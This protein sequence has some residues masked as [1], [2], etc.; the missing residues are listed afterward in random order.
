M[1]YQCIVV[2]TVINI[3]PP[4][5][6]TPSSG[7][8]NG[9]I[10]WFKNKIKRAVAVYLHSLKL[11]PNN[12]II[13]GNLACIYYKQ[14]FIDLAIETYRR[15][16]EFQPNFPDAYCNLANALKEKGLV[17]EAE[18][19]YNKALHL[20]P[21]HVDTLNNLGNVK[22]EQGKIEEATKLYMRALEVFPNFAA[23][24]SNLA[25]LLQHQG[26]L[27]EAL[28]HYRQAISVQPKFADAYSNMG[29]TLRELQD[30][31]G[32]FVCFKKAIEINPCFADAHCNLASIYKDMG[33]ITD[34]IESYK[35]AL[36]LK[37]E[38]PDAY[39]NL[40]HCLQII[41]NWDHYNERMSNIISIV[42][43]QLSFEKLTSVH[44]HHS[45]LYPL[46][47]KVR[48]EI[49]SRHA[50]IFSEKVKMFEHLF[51]NHTRESKGRLRVGYVSSD[52]G[53]HPTSHLMQSIP[54]LH[55]QE[56]IEV[57]CYALN[58]N[59]GTTF[60]SKI[61][62]ESEHYID[63]SKI[64]CN[65]EAAEIIKQNGI[66]I[67]I[68]MNGYTKGARNEIFALKPAPIQVMWLGYPGTSGAD[69]M[70]YIITDETSSPKWAENDFS[71]KFAYMS[72]TYF[73]G[74]HKQ[75]FPHLKTQYK[76]NIELENCLD[77]N[78]AFINC[79][80]NVNIDNM[81][82]TNHKKI[83]LS[84]KQYKPIEVIVRTIDIPSYVVEMT[85]NP[86]QIMVLVEGKDIDNGLSINYTNKKVASGENIR[87]GIVITSRKQYGLPNDAIIY[88]NF[89]Q[90]YKIDPSVMET[91]VNILKNVP[92][93][94]LWLL[95]FPAAGEPNIRKF[96]QSL[97]LTPDRII[98]SKI[99]CKEEHVR[100]GQL[101]DVCLDTPLCNGHTTAMDV[102]WTGTPV[103]TLP[104]ET[105]ASRVAASQLNA[106]GCSELIAKSKQEYQD[107]AV[108]LGTNSQYRRY[109]R[110]KVSKA[111]LES[112]LFDC[113]HYARGLETLY[114]NMWKCY[115]SGKELHHI[116]VSVD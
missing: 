102:L 44:P 116:R 46:S 68:N 40:V 86:K 107:L 15:A 94:V 50:N 2:Y 69:F 74:D 27:H 3:A 80:E 48:K 115:Q 76:V 57:F 61:N 67:L 21:A 16:I 82:C 103:I 101:A 5:L 110:A 59:D 42:E 63:L 96:A 64:T 104:G 79:A 90:L 56:K 17:S 109:I 12:G 37:P 77:I 45:I 24:H 49:A 112:T 51:F 55:N 31:T 108:R 83:S 36:K 25:S 32:A 72:Q 54:G 11:T 85:V 60:R 38:F 19:C 33:N 13:H 111:R 14:G 29:N 58:P 35:I 52:F 91:W 65:I 114:E 71:E 95:S 41:C 4:R 81:F 78:N 6:T 8:T 97:G 75:M 47:N 98:F 26:K 30:V 70:D 66:N 84:Y 106:L 105:L 87:N 20:C 23:T 10:T 88:C 43:K 99:A 73:I 100:R 22:R 39:C 92:N 18:E 9:C 113:E 7:Y 62:K 34:A 53:N 1:D 89:N 93:S 28:M